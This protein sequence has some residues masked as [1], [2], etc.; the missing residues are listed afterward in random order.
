VV[1]R[2][3]LTRFQSLSIRNKLLAMVLL[4][5]AGVLPLLG[6]LLLWWSNQAFDQMLTTKVRADLAV[7]GWSRAASGESRASNSEKSNLLQYALPIS[8]SSSSSSSFCHSD[9][10]QYCS[11]SPVTSS[12]VI[13]AT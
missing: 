5:L 1:A 8:V 10:R 6:L 3:T 7:A 11:G 13:F 9:K 12:P 2:V 4:P